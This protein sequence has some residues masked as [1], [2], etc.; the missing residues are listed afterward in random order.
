MK[1][2]IL[3]VD[4]IRENRELFKNIIQTEFDV[5]IK[6]ACNGMEAL[7]KTR[8]ESFDIILMDVMMPE[9]NGY[10]TTKKI[11]SIE[12][13][14]NSTIIFITAYDE[15]IKHKQRALDL[16]GIDFIFKPVQIDELNRLIGLYLRFIRREKDLTKELRK[17]NQSLKEEINKRTLFEKEYLRSRESFKN[18]VGKSEAAILIIDDEGILKFMN[19]SAEIV[20]G[21][22]S[23]ELLGES[24]GY[25]AQ[26]ETKAEINIL[27]TDGTIGVGEITTTKTNWESKSAWL[28]L[29]N[30]IT[31]HKKLQENLEKAKEKA[32]ESDRL[33]S[34][35]LSNMSHEIRTPMNG[36]LGFLDFIDQEENEEQRKYYTNVIRN[37]GNHLL[38]LIND[39]I[40]ISKIEA[41]QLTIKPAPCLVDA[42]LIGIYQLFNNHKKVIEN[43]VNL[44]LDRM[45]KGEEL[46]I[47]TDGSRLNQILINLIGNAFKFTN[48]GTIKFGYKIK[49]KFLE[50]FVRDTGK[51]IPQHMQ[52]SIFNRFSQ[53]QDQNIEYQQGT[54]LGLAISRSLVKLLGGNIWLES[55]LKEGTIF[56]FTIPF[57]KSEMISPPASKQKEN[58]HPQ[59]K[60]E[61]KTAL[62]VDD[63]VINYN[64]IQLQLKST[65]LKTKWAKNGYEAVEFSKINNVDIIF[66]DIKMPGMNGLEATRQIRK[67][68]NNIPIIAQTAY[69]LEGEK[70]KC[71]EAGCNDY[72]SKPI[73]KELLLEL[74][75]KYT[76]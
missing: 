2:K 66:M 53:V 72:I 68:K 15:E 38:N 52:E 45:I 55:A 11:K 18:I 12:K 59:I 22:S 56:Y 54:G 70:E 21:R 17:S 40:D 74:L 65:G 32:Q 35:F 14:A 63:E 28:I 29:I 69:A 20:F 41:G 16:G 37:S 24:F 61:E 71:L 51:G 34:A 1:E 58:S 8:N 48:S 5:T 60:F 26:F 39:I 50:F 76:S 3:I 9:L 36:I 44:E 64:L 46:T 75:K 43:Q 4:D 47:E 19:K 25:I 33:K 30:D 7:K 73:N 23:D 27:R 13:N 62:I 42:L 57:I 10:E 6:E 49:D 31:E 67:I